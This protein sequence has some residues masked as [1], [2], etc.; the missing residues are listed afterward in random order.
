MLLRNA[1]ALAISLCLALSAQ[2]QARAQQAEHRGQVS[3]FDAA[4]TAAANSGPQNSAR[5][6]AQRSVADNQI[7][8]LVDPGAMVGLANLPDSVAPALPPIEG[9]GVDDNLLPLKLPGYE[10]RVLDKRKRMLYN[11]KGAW[12]EAS[13]PVYFYYPTEPAHKDRALAILRRVYDDVLALGDKPQWTA[14]EFRNVLV[15]LDAALTILETQDGQV[16]GK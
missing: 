12:V 14:A 16:A 6:T 9:K 11:I 15:N 2:A 10:L 3:G 5:Q 13:L 1:L 7:E 8:P 4:L